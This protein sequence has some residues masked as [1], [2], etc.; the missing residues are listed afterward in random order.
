MKKRRE[1]RRR[2]DA[3]PRRATPPRTRLPRPNAVLTVLR[4]AGRPLRLEELKSE[5]GPASAAQAEEL[6]DTLVRAGEVVLNR[7]G[8]YCLREQLP[9]LA[10]GT[11]SANRNGDGQ[12]HAG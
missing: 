1:Q 3:A 12:L 5:L 8:Q 9:G 6:L 2:R 7:R 10:V 11:V 4:S